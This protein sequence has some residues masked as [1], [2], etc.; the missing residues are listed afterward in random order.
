VKH[1]T[2]FQNISLKD[3]LSDIRAKAELTEYL[4]DKVVRHSRSSNYRLKKFMVTSRTHSK[5]NVDIPDLLLTHSQ[6]EAHMLLILYA[7]SVNALRHSCLVMMRSWMHYQCLEMT[8]IC[9]RYMFAAGRLY[10]CAVS[11]KNPHKSK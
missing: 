6:E 10:L 5:G 1:T 11:V 9:P 2:L 4:A 3:F 8:T 7:V